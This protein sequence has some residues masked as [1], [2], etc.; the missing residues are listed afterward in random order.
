MPN[1]PPQDLVTITPNTVSNNRDDKHDRAEHMPLQISI[2]CGSELVIKEVRNRDPHEPS[3]SIF[4]EEPD[5]LVK[6]TE[7]SKEIR[8]RYCTPFFVPQMDT[9]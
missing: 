4:V 3:V 1:E 9:P 7:E 6:A 8:Q 5:N 2:E